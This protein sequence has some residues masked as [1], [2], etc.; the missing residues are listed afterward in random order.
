MPQPVITGMI[1]GAIPPLRLG[2]VDRCHALGR[3]EADHHVIVMRHC[4][5]A[6]QRVAALALD[7]LNLVEAKNYEV[8]RRSLNPGPSGEDADRYRPTS[9]CR[10]NPP[11]L[12]RRVGR[13]RGF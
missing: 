6:R 3:C 8:D 12:V 5:K 7:R 10:I 11:A 13:R 1:P 4:E 2:R 9:R